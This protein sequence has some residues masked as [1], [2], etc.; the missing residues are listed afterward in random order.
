MTRIAI[1]YYSA[2]GKNYEIARAIEAGA[3]AAGAET[4][5]GKVRELSDPAV[6]DANPIWRAHLDA[7]AQVPE[8]S[9]DDLD[10]ADGFA[11]G[12]PTRFGLPA[13]SLKHFMDQA[14]GL[15][16]QGKLADKPAAGFASSGYDHGG[17]ESTL[18]A[19]YNVF[20]AWGSPI[21]PMGY[22]DPAVK[23]AGGNPYGVSFTDPRKEAL[24]EVK[25][26]AARYLGGRLTRYAAVL[27]KNRA[28]L[29]GA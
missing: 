12:S 26:A 9:L 24:P 18:L 20:Y 17:Q 4:R 29:K 25:L 15:W 6:I 23:A 5:L 8:A 2:T 19:L 1:V 13:A 16:S 28:A 11:F 27:S 14:G 10:W 21:V 22:T 3:Q 7:T